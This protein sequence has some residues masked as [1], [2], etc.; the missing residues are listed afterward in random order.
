MIDNDISKNA[1][2]LHNQDQNLTNENMD[3][4]EAHELGSLLTLQ[5]ALS[6]LEN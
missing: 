6:I 2:R 5:E 4:L 1:T 3:T